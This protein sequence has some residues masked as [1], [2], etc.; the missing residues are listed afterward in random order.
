MNSNLEKAKNLLSEGVYT[1]AAVNGKHV[2]TSSERGV[3]PLLLLLDAGESL[4]GFSAADKVIGKAAAF[5]YILLGAEKIY[6][7]VISE[8]ALK[9]LENH[10]IQVEYD[11]LTRAI[12][13]RNN[14]GLCP[15][16][17]AVSLTDDP[18]T[19]LV[20]IR[21]KLRGLSDK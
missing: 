11:I 7:E 2:L 16:E 4:N 20:L 14:T 3:K 9:V 13:N 21:K 15:M 1:F 10:G 5:L 17:S 18:D 19:A 6:S 8:P 12:R